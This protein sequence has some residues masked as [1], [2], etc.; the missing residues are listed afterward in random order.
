[1]PSLSKQLRMK[2][3]AKQKSFD[4]DLEILKSGNGFVINELTKD[5]IFVKRNA[6]KGAIHGDKVKIST[7]NS[8]YGAFLKFQVEKI[9]KRN[10]QYYTAKV[11]KQKKQVF[12]CIYPF[13][14]KKIVLKNLN[15]N[16]GTGDIVKIQIINWREN[17]KTAYA[18]IVSLVAKS[19]D[20]YSEYIWVSQRYGINKF[21]DY[22][23]SKSDQNKYK[24]ILES[25]LK[26]RKDLS[27]LRT[28][29]VDPKNAKDFDDA[30]SIIK[31]NH[32]TELYVHIA[33]V[34][35]YVKE[36]SK[37]DRLAFEKGNSY[38]FD[39]KTTHMLPEFLSTDICSLV[40]GKKR[41]A[42]TAKILLD[43]QCNVKSF[44]FFESTIISDRKFHYGEV[45]KILFD[46][47]CEGI[48]KDIK[49]LKLLTDK[50]RKNR[51]S[52]DGFNLDLYE[53]DFKLDNYGNPIDSYEIEK[54]KSHGM[55]EESMLLANN[56]A[57]KQ[58]E[59]T[60]SRLNRFGI[61][62]NHENLS[63][64]NENF[65]KVLINYITK[66]PVQS[67]SHIKASEINKF[68]NQISTSKKRALS[69][70]IVRKMQ[71]AN[72]STKSLG[73]YGLGLGSYTHFT[74]PIRRYSDIIA[75]RMIKGKFNKNDNI[76][77]IICQCNS[78]ELRSQNA[79]RE[80]IALKGLKL[81]EHLK[82]N[83]LDGFIT[84]IQRSRIIVNERHSGVDGIILKQY[85]PRGFYEFHKE[86]L[87][88]RNKIGTE[89]FSVGDKVKIKVVS[90]DFIS[91]MVF[92]SF[93]K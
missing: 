16:F 90:I 9:I 11:Y 51:L 23:V 57:A 91:Q 89:K 78:G 73:H 75:H 93:D 31:R 14:S 47:S 68:L 83:T 82:E 24:S 15:D 70:I 6:L 61:Y 4:G 60:Q 26:N 64:K 81:L 56:L 2:Y 39:E 67:G 19:D 48:F 41:L 74:S 87:Y 69:H 10:N 50:L 38:Y 40:P 1:M 79:E 43:N 46:T 36:N 29:T 66:S 13:Q 33:D 37:I 21:K 3:S 62:R 28:F 85:I 76:F 77:S 8:R 86:M 42:L 54:L 84:K 30:I 45:E 5:K 80:Y 17:H 63:M 20:P 65:L 59:I 92:F 58:I 49:E 44:D 71:K 18:K 52:K 72:Y 55:I 32:H 25:N 22:T 35:S 34:S 12:A 7:K 27:S 53:P 88:M